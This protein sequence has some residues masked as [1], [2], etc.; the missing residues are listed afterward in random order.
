MNIEILDEELKS[1]AYDD[2][3]FMDRCQ[4]TEEFMIILNKLRN[5]KESKNYSREQLEQIANN[6]ESEDM[7]G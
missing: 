1:M 4:T 3:Y 6:L 2:Y 7:L 5:L